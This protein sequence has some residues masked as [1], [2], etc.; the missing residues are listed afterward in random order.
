MRTILILAALAST[1]NAGGLFRRSSHRTCYVK[2]CVT[3]HVAHVPVV[4]QQA[5]APPTQ[6]QAYAA[7]IP[8]GDTVYATGQVSVQ[9][10]PQDDGRD[11]VFELARLEKNLIDAI[12]KLHEVTASTINTY[13]TATRTQASYN[14]EAANGGAVQA[15]AIQRG[16]TSPEIA[17]PG[18]LASAASAVD[19]QF[20]AQ[21]YCA[22]CHQQ[23]NATDFTLGQLDTEG[24]MK[25]VLSGAMP[26]GDVKPTDAERLALARHFGGL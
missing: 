21:T 4:Q 8:Y 15:M 19:G 23:G 5:Y 13:T 16:V 22:K 9:I 3:A 24:A 17:S 10:G 7:P 6:V 18:A 26:K 20:L 14:I 1:A 2:P 25:Q 11:L 12:P